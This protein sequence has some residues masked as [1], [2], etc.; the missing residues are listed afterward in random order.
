MRLSAIAATFDFSTI[1]SKGQTMGFRN[2]AQ[3][4]SQF[5]LSA[6]QTA[7][8]IPRAQDGTSA[9]AGGGGTR[10]R[11]AFKAGQEEASKTARKKTLIDQRGRAG[12]F[13][14]RPGTISSHGGS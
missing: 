14:N 12:R 8:S 1:G 6:K 13:P 11:A 10:P 9:G 7:E 4:V 5:T 2:L 3:A